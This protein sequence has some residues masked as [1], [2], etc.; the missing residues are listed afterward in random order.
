VV[1]ATPDASG[2]NDDELYL[3]ANNFHEATTEVRFMQGDCNDTPGA[4]EAMLV[5]S[6]CEEL[7]LVEEEKIIMAARVKQFLRDR[8]RKRAP[9][10]AA[11]AAKDARANAPEA[12]QQ[13]VEERALKKEQQDAIK[14]DHVIVGEINE[15]ILKVE[16]ES[17]LG[18]L[19]K[20]ELKRQL[21]EKK[22]PHCMM[23][24]KIKGIRDRIYALGPPNPHKE[25]ADD[26]ALKQQAIVD[27]LV[28]LGKQ[29]GRAA[30]AG[31]WT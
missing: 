9:H 28:E 24:P 10:L 1:K 23:Y 14:E 31:Q 21:K 13:K 25:L 18:D 4:S 11:M 27:R 6:F 16:L 3:M 5:W 17:E 19:E 30:R 22:V 12:L 29:L 8:E 20:D 15:L 7:G 26:F 2:L